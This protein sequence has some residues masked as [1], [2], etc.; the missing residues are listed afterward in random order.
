VGW[1]EKLR[2]R[3][4]SDQFQ[5][6]LPVGAELGNNNHFRR[7]WL[8]P[9]LAPFF[10]QSRTFFEL[11]TIAQTHAFFLLPNLAPFLTKLAPFS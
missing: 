9:N 4:N 10:A 1:A 5:L 11:N 8:V 7:N 2:I 3:L 6:K